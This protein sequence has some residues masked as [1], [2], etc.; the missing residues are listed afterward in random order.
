MEPPV[1]ILFFAAAAY[2][3][4]KFYSEFHYRKTFKSKTK[5]E[6]IEIKDKFDQWFLN[7]FFQDG[8]IESC[9]TKGRSY[10]YGDVLCSNVEYCLFEPKS[11]EMMYLKRTFNIYLW[12]EEP[13]SAYNI[14]HLDIP[15][16]YYQKI[17]VKNKLNY[18]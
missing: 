17:R 2:L 5:K 16:D 1:I 4:N 11:F 15:E 14:Q 18:I 8:L 7:N 12:D 10:A 3:F 13:A 9:Y 6:L